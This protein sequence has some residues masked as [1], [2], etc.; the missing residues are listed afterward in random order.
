MQFLNINADRTLCGD[1]LTQSFIM[2]KYIFLICHY[3]TNFQDTQAL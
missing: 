2:S 1:F 3:L